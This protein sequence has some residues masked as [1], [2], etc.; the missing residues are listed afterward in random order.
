MADIPINYYSWSVA[1]SAI[2]T[3]SKTLGRDNSSLAMR[4]KVV[5]CSALVDS[6]LPCS[7]I[8][9]TASSKSFLR[10]FLSKKTG[11]QATFFQTIDRGVQEIF[12]KCGLLVRPDGCTFQAMGKYARDC[13]S[14]LLFVASNQVFG[15]FMEI[16]FEGTIVVSRI[17]HVALSYAT[18]LGIQKNHFVTHRKADSPTR[19]R[20]R[21]Q[22]LVLLLCFMQRLVTIRAVFAVVGT[23][24]SKATVVV[25]VVPVGQRQNH[26]GR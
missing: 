14:V 1:G 19:R 20:R 25:V 17:P 12:G 7:C 23:A 6:N 18:A 24:G 15:I 4:R 5:R 10:D 8:V 21:R 11:L 9:C 3:L 2:C 26:L 16:V 22:G 13:C